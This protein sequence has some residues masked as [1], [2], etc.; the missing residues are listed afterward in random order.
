MTNIG[1]ASQ[2]L[3]SSNSSIDATEMASIESTAIAATL[4]VGIGKAGIALSGA[5]VNQS[6]S[7]TTMFEDIWITSH[8]RQ[9][10]QQLIY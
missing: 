2:P 9:A 6:T 5:G 3:T 7:L 10:K 8:Y 4:A 1:S